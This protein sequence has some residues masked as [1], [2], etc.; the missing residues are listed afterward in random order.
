MITFLSLAAQAQDNA[1]LKEQIKQQ[2]AMYTNEVWRYELFEQLQE[3]ER[4]LQ[5]EPVLDM[6]SWDV[7]LSGALDRLERLR[8]KYRQAFLLVIADTGISPMSY[9]RPAIMPT[10]LLLKPIRKEELMAVIREMIEVFSEK[11]AEDNGTEVFIIDSREGRQYIPYHQI[12]YIEAKEKKIY[13]RTKQEEYGFYETIENME[14]QLPDGFCRCHRSYIV[15][16]DKVTLIKA[17]QNIIE[18][19]GDIEVPLSRSYKKTVK[20]YHKNAGND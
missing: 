8:Q 2:A 13:I 19:Q 17:S 11:F 20:D 18:L 4:F 5:D 7:T 6:I 1:V 9:L 3:L 16:M 10:S 15:N 14:K 12:Y